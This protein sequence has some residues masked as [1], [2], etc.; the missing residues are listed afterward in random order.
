MIWHE[1]KIE[2]Y[3]HHQNYERHAFYEYLNAAKLS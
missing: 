3:N 1:Q 2:K